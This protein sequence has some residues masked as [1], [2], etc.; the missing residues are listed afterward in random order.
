[1]QIGRNPRAV[2]A[3]I[4][5][6][7]DDILDRHWLLVAGRVAITFMYFALVFGL[8]RQERWAYPATFALLSAFI[9]FQLHRYASTHDRG[10][11]ALTILDLVVMALT[12]N[13][14]RVRHRWGRSIGQAGSASIRGTG[15]SCAIS[16]LVLSSFQNAPGMLVVI[17]VR[18]ARM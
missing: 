5:R 4:E 10:L 3:E 2:A 13:E 12:W 17:E 7:V 9:A 8:L 18:S 1:M 11:V 15:A 16:P 6:E 14:Y